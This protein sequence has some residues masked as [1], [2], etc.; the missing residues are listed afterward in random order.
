MMLQTAAIARRTMKLILA[1]FV[2]IVLIVTGLLIL[3]RSWWKVKEESQRSPSE[4]YRGN[5]ASSDD[6]L[7][8]RQKR[9][10]DDSYEYPY[11]LELVIET[12]HLI[13]PV[14]FLVAGDDEIGTGRAVLLNGGAYRRYTHTKQGVPPDHPNWFA[15]EWETPAFTTDAPIVVTLSSKRPI[16]VAGVY[17]VAYAPELEHQ[18]RRAYILARKPGSLAQQ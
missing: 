8:V 9:F 11:G 18:S 7:I 3:A 16:D 4:K 17:P 5:K 12:N 1:S 13:Q 15:F 10:A 2:A 14:A 6:V